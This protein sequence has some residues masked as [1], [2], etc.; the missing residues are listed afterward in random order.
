MEKILMRDNRFPLR[1][2]EIYRLLGVEGSR[3]PDEGVLPMSIQ[4]ITVWVVPKIK[5]KA[6]DGARTRAVCPVCE[7]DFVFDNLRQ[8]M[9]V[10]RR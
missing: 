3:L 6:Q 7:K 9:T 1:C 10:H 2:D 5:G 4:G 8:H